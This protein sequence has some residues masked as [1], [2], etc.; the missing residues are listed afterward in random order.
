[1]KSSLKK[2]LVALPLL[3]IA[4]FAAELREIVENPEG[5][6]RRDGGEP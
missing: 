2:I 5:V 6:F 3:P 4:A 1:M